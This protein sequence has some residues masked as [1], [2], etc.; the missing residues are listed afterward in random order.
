MT[1]NPRGRRGFS[2]V[3]LMVAVTIM[4]IL[5]SFAAPSFTRAVEQSKADVAGANLRTAWSSQRLY[6]LDNPAYSPDFPTLVSAGLLDG[7]FPGYPGSPTPPY[8]LAVVSSDSQTFSITATRN[9]GNWSGSFSIDQ[10][11]T[12]SGTITYDSEIPI[13]PGFQ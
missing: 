7:N 10:T 4:G 11:G 8:S 3:E 6:R 9:G 1:K 5:L 13:S 12:I 2:L